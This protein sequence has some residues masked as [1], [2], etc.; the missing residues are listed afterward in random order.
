MRRIRVLP[1]QFVVAFALI[2]ATSLAL[3]GARVGVRLYRER[4]ALQVTRRLKGHVSVESLAPN[5]LQR[6]LVDETRSRI[7]RQF[8]IQRWHVG[9]EI[10]AVVLGGA[11]LHDS[12]LRTIARA[13]SIRRLVLHGQSVTD[14][15][16]AHI[17]YLNSLRELVLIDTQVTDGGLQQLRRMGQLRTLDVKNGIVTDAGIA[18]LKEALPHL[19]ASVT[20]RLATLD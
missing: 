17:A 10:V 2:V 9:D 3:V 1:Q 12:D 8:G 4:A 6:W 14:N 19:K 18:Q 13:T 15:G 7:D 5:W 11:D 20:T 16:L